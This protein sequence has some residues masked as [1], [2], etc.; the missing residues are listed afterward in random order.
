MLCADICV[1][2]SHPQPQTIPG[3]AWGKEPCDASTMAFCPALSPLEGVHPGVISIKAGSL[4]DKPKGTG[5]RLCTVVDSGT[6]AALSYSLLHTHILLVW[7]RLL[8][9]PAST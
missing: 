5:A 9:R 1:A 4:S 8:R 2:V 7:C 3:S 6:S